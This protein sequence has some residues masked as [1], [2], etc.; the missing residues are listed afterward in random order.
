MKYP[1]ILFLFLY[2]SLA[3]GQG[4]NCD[5]C[6]PEIIPVISPHLHGGELYD[7]LPNA[8]TY[9]SAKSGN[10]GNSNTWNCLTGDCVANPIPSHGA[11]VLIHSSHVIR[12]SEELN[13]G[14]KLLR[15]EGEL[16]IST[17]AN[18]ELKSE[19]IQVMP[20]QCLE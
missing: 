15:I 8:P 20:E 16:R 11:R 4:N 10:W 18:T 12:L 5:V 3:C 7:N 1:L 17:N 9:E 14:L 19:T 6:V 13:E 2:S